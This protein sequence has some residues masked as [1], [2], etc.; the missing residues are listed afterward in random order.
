MVQFNQYKLT[1]STPG[2]S[3]LLE[4]CV[5]ISFNQIPPT[6]VAKN[7]KIPPTRKWEHSCIHATVIEA[8]TDLMCAFKIHQ[9]CW[10]G[11]ISSIVKCVNFENISHIFFIDMGGGGKTNFG[12]TM[13]ASSLLLMSL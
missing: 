2:Y 5:L 9:I 11:Q 12:Y 1:W 7:K 6:R 8:V 4:E 3:S 10:F 13:M